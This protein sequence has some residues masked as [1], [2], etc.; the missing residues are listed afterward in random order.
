MHYGDPSSF[1]AY[2]IEVKN[3]TKERI[4]RILENGTY[5][6]RSIMSLLSLSHNFCGYKA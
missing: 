3:N 6:W 2:V 4:V 1:H 5:S